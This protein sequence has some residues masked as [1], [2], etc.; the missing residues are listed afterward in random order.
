MSVRRDRLLRPLLGF[1]KAELRSYIK[2]RGVAWC[3]DASNQSDRYLRNR[4]R[5]AVVPAMERELGRGCL[6]HLPDMAKI[7]ADEDAY[8]EAEAAR[9]AAFAE[10]G[11]VGDRL[12]DAEGLA[13]APAALRARIVRRWLAAHTGRAAE[14]FSR[15]E[16]E[17][18]LEVA[19][20]PRGTRVAELGG[21]SVAAS[22]GELRVVSRHRGD[23]ASASEFE[24]RLTTDQAVEIVGPG[25]WTIAATRSSDGALATPVSAVHEICD[26]LRERLS[27]DLVV[28][29]ARPGD[30]VSA[31]ERGM[32]KVQDLMVDARIPPMHRATWPLVESA[33]QV[34]WVPGLARDLRFVATE[35]GVERLRLQWRHADVA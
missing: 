28:R 1:S 33:G 3:E 4:I 25:G 10:R 7:W 6:D 30:R 29:S 16:L 20:D 12:L 14:S 24:Y 9:F 22:Y 17:R 5:H 11:P 13:A 26:F 19:S 15:A 23:A 21:C 35:V 18:V 32:R 31:T 2:E 8:L 34:I 27:D